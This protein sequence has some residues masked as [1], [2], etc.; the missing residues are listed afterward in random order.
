[1]STRRQFLCAVT[2]LWI[3]NGAAA[4]TTDKRFIIVLIGPTG[5]GKTTQSEFLKRKFGIPTIAVDDLVLDTDDVELVDEEDE[6]AGDVAGLAG[7]FAHGDQRVLHAGEPAHVLADA[8][9][10]EAGLGEAGPLR[11]AEVDL[12][13]GLIIVGEE[14]SRQRLGDGHA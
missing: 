12:E 9:D 8:L 1:M 4:Q 14:A 2:A 5:S 7:A 11:G 3:H 6:D 13:L 10:D